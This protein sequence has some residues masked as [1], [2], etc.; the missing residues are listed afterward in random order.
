MLLLEI[1]IARIELAPQASKARLLPLNY[2]PM[3][4]TKRLELLLPYGNRILSPVCLPIPP[5]Q[6]IIIMEPNGFEPLIFHL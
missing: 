2:I 1:G 6:Q 4:L 5:R 3:I